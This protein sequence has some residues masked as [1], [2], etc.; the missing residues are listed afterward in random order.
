MISASTFGQGQ[1]GNLTIDAS[2]VVRLDGVSS[3]GFRS[4]LYAQSF[5]TGIGG[6]LR[7]NTRELI[8]SNQARITVAANNLSEFGVPFE[9]IEAILKS[10]F[11]DQELNKL[12]PEILEQPETQGT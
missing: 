5:A 12:I 2:E 1:G 9:V 7:I 11:S 3:L 10:S 6:N 4:G 8:I